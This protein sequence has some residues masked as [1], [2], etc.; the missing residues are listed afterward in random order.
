[1]SPAGTVLLLPAGGSRAMPILHR[2]E[3][4]SADEEAVEGLRLAVDVGRGARG[5]RP[6]RS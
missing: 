1:M 3:S 5:Q 6:A 2:E 4:E